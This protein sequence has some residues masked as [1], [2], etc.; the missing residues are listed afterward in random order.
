MTK[1]GTS[2]LEVSRLCLGGNVFG[3]TADEETSFAVLDGYA[4]AGGTF[5]DTA[6]SYSAW[7]EGHSGGESETIIGKWL[8]SCGNRDGMVVAT[9]VGMLTGMD[10]LK[11]ATIERAAED[12]LRRL[13]VDHIDLYYAHRDDPDT[14]QEETLAA[15]DRLVRAGKVRHVAASNYTAERL[16]SAL[17]VSEREGFAKFVALQQA[18]NLVDRSYEGELSRAVADHGL[19]SAPYWGLAKGFLTGKYR[20]GVA[21]ESARAVGASKYLDE[22]GLRILDAVDEVAGNHG[23]TQAAVALA[24]LAEQPTVAAPIASART[25][26]QLA[27]LVPALDLELKADEIAALSAASRV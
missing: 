7:A 4:R 3:W 6:D 10:D 14:P 26:E 22:R 17:A 2:D 16:T 18:Y 20:P 21:V 24:W 25:A 23:T 27:D 8:R 12:S 11:A 15:F 9:K 19:S 5:V 13:G 1:L